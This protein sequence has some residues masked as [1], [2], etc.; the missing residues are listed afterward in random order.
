MNAIDNLDSRALRLT[1]CYGQRFM[2]EGRFSW[3]ALPAGGAM[4]VAERPF[5]IEAR[6]RTSKARW[7]STTWCCAGTRAASCPTAPS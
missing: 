5:T 1:D 3:N 7:R 4:M 6:P 2:R